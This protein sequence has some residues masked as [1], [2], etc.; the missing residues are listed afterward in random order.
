[1]FDYSQENQNMVINKIIEAG[2]SAML[3]PNMGSDKDTLLVYIDKD[4]FGQS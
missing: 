3:R 4:R 1:V 2:Y